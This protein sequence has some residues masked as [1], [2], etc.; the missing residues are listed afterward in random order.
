M[1]KK[2]Q[3]LLMLESSQAPLCFSAGGS[4]PGLCSEWLACIISPV[5]EM[6]AHNMLP[7]AASLLGR[8]SQG[9]KL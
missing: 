6:R 7:K 5:T 2:L 3:A 8:S 9:K 4:L 1:Q